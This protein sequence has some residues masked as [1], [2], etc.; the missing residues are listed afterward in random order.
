MILKVFHI[1]RAHRWMPWMAILI[2]PLALFG[3]ALLQGKALFWG[4]P[5]LQ[6]TPWHSYAAQV[7][8]AGHLPLWNPLVG[9]GA[10]LLA[11]YQSGLLYPPNFLLMFTSVAWGQTLLVMLHLIWAGAG[12]VRLGRILGFGASGQTVAAL[13]FSLSGY[14]VARS[15]FMSINAT[16]A[17]LPWIIFAVER[18][19]Q[20]LDETGWSVRK[21]TGSMALLAVFLGFQW[22]AGHAQISW[23]SMVL[24]FL[25][26]IWRSYDRGAMGSLFAGLRAFALSSLFAFGLAAAQLLPTLEFTA[27]SHRA[28]G[29]DPGFAMNYS[30]WPWR[31]LG[32]FAPG[33]FGTQAGGDFWGYGNFWE[34]A[35]YLGMLPLLLALIHIFRRRSKMLAVFAGLALVFALGRNTPVFPF[36]YEHIPTFDL[37]QAPTRW[38]FVLIFCLALMAGQSAGQWKPP[39]GRGLYWLR[40]GTAGAAA[41][42]LSAWLA[43][44]LLSDINP[45][46]APAISSAGLML[47]A[48]GVLLLLKGR[49]RRTVW[50][51]AVTGVILVDLVIAG[52]HL[53]AFEGPELQEAR[54]SS[55]RQRLYIPR[56]LEDHLKFEESFRF[57]TFNPEFSW[58][59]VREWGL[60][61]ASMLR[62]IPMVNN[63]DPLVTE[64]YAQWMVALETRPDN[65]LM[66]LMG[67]EA[68]ATRADTIGIRY[69]SFSGSERVRLYD[70]ALVIDDPDQVLSEVANRGGDLVVLESTVATA[71][72]AGGAPASWVLRDGENPN[73]LDVV[74]ETD[75][76]A[77]LVLSDQWYPGWKAYVDEV[78]STL[79]RAN[80]LFRGVWV[81]PGDHV[82]SFQYQPLTFAV[83]AILSLVTTLSLA[84][85]WWR[86][87]K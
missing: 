83:G 63:F 87:S 40:L 37:F 46:F 34:D 54:L 43:S 52:F 20:H 33:L 68:V 55:G 7:I 39:K 62:G 70:K 66:E 74:V 59:L 86:R 81:P 8:R 35:I 4:A 5:L 61:N 67:V 79:Y 16:A 28:S 50:P 44:R 25:W 13:A 71:I 53:N 56:A 80:Y 11:N 21:A 85:L 51:F 31:I 1:R 24:A 17:W 29:L 26:L 45:T 58:E 49:L 9:M 36:L 72:E 47:S 76:G 10:P 23:Y 30:L 19:L 78:E 64:R 57:D 65:R 42:T 84:S 75:N 18:L 14:L 41:I 15:G 12:M 22:T 69:L 27:I 73:R 3:P 2:G 77:W 38:S 6:F 60:P 82:V 32:A 48:A